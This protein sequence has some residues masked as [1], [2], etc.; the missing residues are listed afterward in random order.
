MAVW[1][2]T[3]DAQTAVI[4]ARSDTA[5][6]LRSDGHQETI[7]PENGTYRLN[8]PGATNTNG[9]DFYSPAQPYY[10]PSPYMIGGQTF[11]LIEEYS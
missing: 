2:L 6:L 8:L 1:S 10:D 11:I 3:G 4:P 9:F 7:R 5:L